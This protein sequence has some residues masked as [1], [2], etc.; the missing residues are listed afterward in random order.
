MVALRLKSLRGWRAALK[1]PVWEVEARR[2]KRDC[3]ALKY[4]IQTV[5]LP[6]RKPRVV[7]VLNPTRGLGMKNRYCTMIKRIGWE[8]VSRHWRWRSLGKM[9]KPAARNTRGVRVQYLSAKFQR[10]TLINYFSNELL[11]F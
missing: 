9:N 7:M 5:L 1:S 8:M 2:G 4:T 11:E 6:K 10:K 3:W